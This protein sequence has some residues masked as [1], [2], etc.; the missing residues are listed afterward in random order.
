MS[1]QNLVQSSELIRFAETVRVNS[2]SSQQRPQLMHQ[3]PQQMQ[4]P[5]LRQQREQLAVCKA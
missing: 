4:Q 3:K 2:E 1:E 5:R